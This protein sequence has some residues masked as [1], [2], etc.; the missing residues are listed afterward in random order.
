MIIGYLFG[1]LHEHVV[2]SQTTLNRLQALTA[3]QRVEFHDFAFLA[4]QPSRFEQDGIRNPDFPNVV[5]RGSQ[6]NGMNKFLVDRIDPTAKVLAQNHH[7][8]ANAIEVLTGIVIPGFGQFGQAKNDCVLG[9]NNLFFAFG[10]STFQS[11]AMIV[12]LC[13]HSIQDGH[14]QAHASQANQ[15]RGRKR[16]LP[17][18]LNRFRDRNHR[19]ALL[20]SG[21]Q[22]PFSVKDFLCKNEM[23]ASLE[24]NRT[25]YFRSLPRRLKQRLAGISS[26]IETELPP[27]DYFAV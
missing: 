8:T 18:G 19:L 25:R 20:L 26:Q 24:N 21:H 7:V 9:A 16:D 22:D 27:G 1:D 14:D 17:G 6:G 23:W 15:Q 11:L 5:Q 2:I 3:N 12:D 4:S 13:G 10:Q